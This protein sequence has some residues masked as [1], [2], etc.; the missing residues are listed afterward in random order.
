MPSPSPAAQTPPRAVVFDLDGVIFDSAESNIHFYNCILEGIG[1]PPEAR[2][3]F[4]II[5]SEPL[6][7]SLKHLLGE[8]E[9]FGRAMAYCRSL[10]PGQF[11]TSLTLHEGVAQT[12]AALKGRTRLAVATNRTVTCRRALE[13]FGLWELFEEVITP[14]EAGQAKPDPAMMHMMLARLGLAEH[15]VVYVGD[16]EVDEGMC[17]AASVRLVAFRNP[18]L[19]AWA[20]ASHFPDI[21]G[22]LGLA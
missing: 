19:A 2:Q 16:T 6:D 12:L 9:E 8:G 20:H 1:R 13:H 14:R 5:H 22:L 4:E 21:P 18:G 17:R 11:V 10:D 15:E 7:L 3:H